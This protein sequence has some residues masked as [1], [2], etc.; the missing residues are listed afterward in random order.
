MVRASAVTTGSTSVTVPTTVS[1]AASR[2]RSRWRATWSRMMAACSSTLLASGSLRARRSLVDHH[3]QRRL[4]R[5]R[6]IAD[7]GARALDDLLVGVDQLIGL[8]RKR[9]DLFG[10]CASQPLGVP[11]RIAARLSVMRL[12]GASPKRTWNMVVSSSTAARITKVITSAWSNE[13]ISS[14]ISAASPA[15]ATR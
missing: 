2:A 5:M 14:S 15:T 6:Q 11:A 4:Q 12:S 3:R 7:M 8:A 10:E 9:R 1:R 13:R